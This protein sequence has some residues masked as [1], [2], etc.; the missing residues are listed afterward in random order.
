MNRISWYKRIALCSRAAGLLFAACVVLTAVACSSVPKSSQNTKQ[1]VQD[2][3]IISGTLENGMR[4]YIK[5]NSEPKNRLSIRLAVQ[6]G[7][8]Q[9]DDDQQGVAHFVEHMAFNG[10]QHFKGSELVDF[11]ESIGM[12]FGPEINAYTSF[13]ET[14]YMLEL[15][16]DNPEFLDTALTVVYDWACA[17]DFDAEKLENERQVIVEEWRLGLGADDRIMQKQIPFMLPESRYAQRLPIGKTEIIENISRERVIDFYKKWYRPELMSIIIVG[18]AEPAS[19][20]QAVKQHLSAIPATGEIPEKQPARITIPKKDAL[21]VTR[22]PELSS[23]RIDI[24]AYKEPQHIRTTQDL[25]DA[26]VNSVACS[27]FSQRMTELSFGAD[28]PVYAAGAGLQK[29]VD[30]LDLQFAAIIPTPGKFTEALQILLTELERIRKYGVTETELQRIKDDIIASETQRLANSAAISNSSIVAQ[31]LEHSRSGDIVLSAQDRYNLYTE[32]VQSITREQVNRACKDWFP[33]KGKLMTVTAPDSASDI[34]SEQEI[35]AIWQKGPDKASVVPYSDDVDDRPLYLEKPAVSGSILSEQTLLTEPLTVTQWLLSNGVRVIIN[36]T[37]FKQDEILMN[38][39][40][41]GG[42]SYF[43][44]EE[45]QSAAAAAE[46]VEQ[47]G[48]NGLTPMQVVKK[49]SGKQISIT[50]VIA[51]YYSGLRASCSAA[52]FEDMFRLT[53]LYFTAPYFSEDGWSQ[54]LIARQRQAA[55]LMNTPEGHFYQALSALRYG[56]SPRYAPVTEE[57]ISL[58]NSAAAERA[59]RTC[60]EDANGYTFIF[61]GS[62]DVEQ[63]RTFACDYLATLPSG[64]AENKALPAVSPDSAYIPFPQGKPSVTVKKGLEDQRTVYIAFGGALPAVETD[65]ITLQHQQLDDMTQYLRTVLRETIREQMG[66]SYNVSVYT[67]SAE[68]PSPHYETEIAFSC[69]P[70]RERELADAVIAEIKRL[71]DTLPSQANMTKIQE[72]YRRSMETGLRQNSF[73]LTHITQNV[74]DSVPLEQIADTHRIEQAQ[75][76][77]ALQNT[78]RTMLNTDNYISAYLYPEK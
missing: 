50:P 33:A 63:L 29:F 12:G 2:P 24:M 39:V 59:Y 53:Q 64:Y 38:A 65:D 19:L 67:A 62:F 37:D 42:L 11:F 10:S 47:S 48:L 46:Y 78:L 45:Y 49:L 76:P 44:D 77:Q 6:A 27:I 31:L 18:D 72:Q 35:F 51:P 16:A 34:P 26:L 68:Y 32:A 13:D 30:P 71:Q 41:R 61:T 17:L 56:E 22:D 36:Q 75:T 70:G 74:L 66:G 4:Y 25:K 7:S 57:T 55:Q 15:P 9:E 20:E 69:A 23:T 28:S 3:A 43:S 5:Q 54:V 21:L 58:L 40:R 1:L 60:F 73:W 14:V 52:D 8:M